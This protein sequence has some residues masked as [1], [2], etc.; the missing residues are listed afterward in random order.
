VSDAGHRL[1]TTANGQISELIDLLSTREEADLSLPCPGRAKLGDGTVAACASHAAD[2][3][4][5][6]AAF[7]DSAQK[8][9]TAHGQSGPLTAPP[10]L[11]RPAITQTAGSTANTVSLTPQSRSIV[12]DCS[13]D[14]QPRATRSALSPV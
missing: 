13:S 4:L 11:S 3:Y 10:P 5:R 9:S 1:N 2:N 7:L 6:I 8:T 14:C 12:G